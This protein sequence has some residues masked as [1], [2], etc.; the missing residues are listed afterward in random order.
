MPSAPAT[1]ANFQLGLDMLVQMRTAKRTADYIEQVGTLL[2]KFR[3]DD[4]RT[5]VLADCDVFLATPPYPAFRKD[6]FA[7]LVKFP[8]QND[9]FFLRLA[10]RYPE[11]NAPLVLDFCSNNKVLLPAAIFRRANGLR[12]DINDT[13]AREAYGPKL[14]A[15]EGLVTAANEQ[16]ALKNPEHLQAFIETVVRSGDVFRDGPAPLYTQIALAQ[17][18]AKLATAKA[19][20]TIPLTPLTPRS[21]QPKSPKNFHLPLPQNN[22]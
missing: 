8:L 16:G 17:L 18:F 20:A 7:T 14:K 11:F 22:C 2:D 21:V 6:L 5:R 10:A 19:C 12:T 3:R 9:K 15:I 13:A 1:A 4:W